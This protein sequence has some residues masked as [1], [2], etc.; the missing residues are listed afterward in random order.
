MKVNVIKDAGTIPTTFIETEKDIYTTY[1]DESLDVASVKAARKMHKYLI[2]KTKL[3]AAQ[4][5]MLL[6]LVVNL[7]ISQVVNP[8][9]K[10]V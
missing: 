8:K 10:G 3:T 4:V 7:M 6:S 1:G 5:D 2:D 9:N